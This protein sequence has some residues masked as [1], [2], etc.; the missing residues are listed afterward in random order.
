MLTRQGAPANPQ[1]QRFA[2]LTEWCIVCLMEVSAMKALIIYDSQY[3]CTEKVARAI[4]A[5]LAQAGEAKAFRPAEVDPAM[6]GKLDLLIV[7]SPT[8][9]GRPTKAMA[10]L[11]GKIAADGLKD[12]P[13][14][15]FDTRMKGRMVGVFGFAAGRIETMLKGKGGRSVAS[16]AGFLVDSSKGPLK[17]GEA[18]RAAAWAAEVLEGIRKTGTP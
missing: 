6:L 5:A 9:G 12:V 10:E 14:A 17:E 3:G 1:P 7:G 4:E 13:V 15:A 2:D 8:Q 18:E 11:L 16:P